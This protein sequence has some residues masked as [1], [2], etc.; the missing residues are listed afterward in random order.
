MDILAH[1][2][3]AAAAA[4]AAKRKVRIS[5]SR[6]VWWG[7]FP[8]LAGLGPIAVVHGLGALR[9]DT[10]FWRAFWHT[11]F[12]PVTGAGAGV[13]AIT[14]TLYAATHSIF[15]FAACFG[16]FYLIRKR[17]IPRYGLE[18]RVSPV[19]W[20]LSGWLLH[21]LLDIGTH[22][23]DF[24][25]TPFLWPFF[26]FKVSGI[27]WTNPTFAAINYGTLAIIGIVFYIHRKRKNQA[28]GR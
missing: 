1:S 11:Q 16:L 19:P 13:L 21:I 9:S 27:V 2:L 22:S 4:K 10:N 26:S 15:F 23:A 5:I 7:I 8:D 28:L 12:E 20:E 18:G 17:L 24:Y 3:W 6:T 25:P 14:P